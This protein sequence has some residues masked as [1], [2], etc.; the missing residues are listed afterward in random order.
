MP[1][2]P[3]DDPTPLPIV[4]AEGEGMHYPSL[5]E[6]EP[7]LP[8]YVLH[9]I[10][11]TG[12]MGAVY[13]AHQPALDRWVALKVIPAAASANAEIADLFNREA[14]IMAHLS[15]PH[16]VAVFDYGQT[17][18]GHLYMAME[19]VDGVDLHWRKEAGEITPERARVLVVQLCEALQ[20]A[21][22]QG[23]IHR[24]IK[25]A[26]ILV[27][28]DWQVKVIDFG[29]ARD[30]AAA[31][32]PDEPEYGTP[33]YVAP[34]RLI[35]GKLTDHRAD[36]Y[37][38][39]V[40]LHE[41]LTGKT[42]L[43]ARAA[44]GQGIPEGFAGVLSKCLMHEPARRYQ[45]VSE[46]RAALLAS[47]PVKK[48][49]PTANSGPIGVAPQA[50]SIRPPARIIAPPSQPSAKS[51][52]KL[53]WILACVGLFVIVGWLGWPKGETQRADKKTPMLQC[54]P[55]MYSPRE[56]SPQPHVKDEVDVSP[57]VVEKHTP[58]LTHSSLLSISPEETSKKTP[59]ENVTAESPPMN[60]TIP[61]AIAL[62]VTTV[63]A[64]GVDYKTQVQP[65]L[66]NKCYACHSLAKKVKGD[67]A[68][69]PEEKMVATIGPGKLIIPGEPEK[70]KMLQV[71]KLPDDDSDVMPPKGKNRLTDAEVALL[72]GWIKEGAQLV[73]GAA[74]VAMPAAAPA[75]AAAAAPTKWTSNDGKEIDATFVSLEGEN[76][77]LKVTAT[78]AAF[79][80]PLSRLSAESQAQA[81]AAAGQ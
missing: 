71:C 20:Y 26:N 55:G 56:F 64:F 28:H 14:R 15:H 66:R 59:P 77:T 33:D 17:H 36:I 67:L 68:M 79:T 72:E 70:S 57:S 3:S 19:Y 7:L 49:A 1:D 10:I 46:I 73:P 12:G 81:K 53:S 60:K 34:E 41:I 76:I 78:G 80:F 13:L 74:P 62:A 61:T 35:A 54:P 11:G 42:P 32:N 44:A 45:K 75:P 38:I 69:D 29:L 39:G 63:T 18:A 51:S 16:I 48:A 24:D 37:S 21:H 6:L 50:P 40:V 4:D 47:A 52:L 43:A 22:D 2:T 27:T 31:T 8:Q 9:R 23:V 58:D 25:P 30:L 65:I 5:E